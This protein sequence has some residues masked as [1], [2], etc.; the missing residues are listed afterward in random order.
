MSH[1]RRRIS[2]YIGSVV[3][4][5]VG[6]VAAGLLLLI[7]V[8]DE[9]A[10][11]AIYRTLGAFTTASIVPEPD[12]SGERAVSAGLAIAGGLFYLFLVGFVVREIAL[13]RLLSQGWADRA[14]RRRIRG[15]TGHYIV[16]GYGNIGRAVVREFLRRGR[17]VVLVDL[18]AANVE[19]A[20]ADARLEGH[21]DDLLVVEG[22]ASHSAVLE[23][24]GIATAAALVACVG[25]D[26]ENLFIALTA[27]ACSSG[28]RVVARAADDEGARRL[29]STDEVDAVWSPYASAGEGIVGLAL[30]SNDQGAS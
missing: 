25:T 29:R 28:V 1:E 21:D 6:I 20:R 27:K 12:S 19:R 2:L 17:K 24:A 18:K 11:E 3:V 16:C 30:A 15:L 8:G 23:K 14:I 13:R 9:P 22:E 10:S 26:G 4:L 5:F 7:W